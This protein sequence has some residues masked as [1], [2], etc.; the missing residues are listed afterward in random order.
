MFSYTLKGYEKKFFHWLYQ[1]CDI[2]NH[3]WRQHKPQV[4]PSIRNVA[5]F[6]ANNVFCFNLIFLL[7]P[8]DNNVSRR[9]QWNIIFRRLLLKNRFQCAVL[10]TRET[11]LLVYETEL[12]VYCFMAR[13]T[14]SCIAC[15]EL[16]SAH[17]CP[18]SAL[19][20]FLISN[21]NTKTRGSRVCSV[22]GTDYMLP[23][24]P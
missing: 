10:T 14:G 23:S 24:N 13:R 8:E 19:N 3:T 15:L 5:Y 20:H 18:H 12:K 17:E 7:R 16:A 21:Q 1:K 22:C 2:S 9:R 4:A 11:A 6:R